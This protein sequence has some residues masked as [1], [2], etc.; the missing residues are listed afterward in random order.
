MYLLSQ[1]KAI[2]NLIFTMF[3]RK[4]NLISMAT[5]RM[6]GQILR[7]SHKDLLRFLEVKHWFNKIVFIEVPR[8]ITHLASAS[9]SR[10]S[11]QVLRRQHKDLP[12]ARIATLQSGDHQA[13]VPVL[14]RR[15]PEA[16]LASCDNGNVCAQLKASCIAASLAGGARRVILHLARR[17]QL[18]RHD[19][20]IHVQSLAFH[21]RSCCQEHHHGKECKFH[22]SV[23]TF[24]CVSRLCWSEC[25]DTCNVMFS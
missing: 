16:P 3:I 9:A 13:K 5:S 17:V 6:S 4:R 21:P 19:S 24:R 11:G 25:T 10:R 20:P 15:T 1:L 12:T 8:D 7:H 14:S 22:I 18:G 2:S 23:I